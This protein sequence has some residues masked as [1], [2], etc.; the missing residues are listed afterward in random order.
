MSK[1]EVTIGLEIHAELNTKTKAFCGCANEYGAKPNTNVCHVCLAIPGTLP[2]INRAAVEKT[3]AAGLAID[4]K[5]ND[6]AVFERKHYFYPDLAKGYQ[7]SQLEKPICLGGGIKLGTG[8]FIRLN[9]IHLEEDAG[10]LLH[11]AVSQISLV[12]YNRGGVPLIEIVTEPD[13]A[14]ATEAVEFLEEVRQRLV[15]AG[16]AECR[17][18]QGGMRCDVNISL[19]PKGAKKLG[20]RC[21][22]KNLN[23]FKSVAR[24]I[25][26][27]AKRQSELLDKG[28]TI[29]VQ[30]RKW[31]EGAGKTTLMRDKGEAYDYR[32]FPD[33]DI[34]PIRITD[35][36]VAEIKVAM[37]KLAHELKT[38]FVTEFGLPEYDAHVLTKNKLLAHF[39]LDCVTLL[40]EPKAVS[41]WTMVD[42][43]KMM[44]DANTDVP[45][46][47]PAQLTEIIKMAMDKTITKTIGL[48]LLQKVSGDSRKSPK[49]IAKDMGLLDGVSDAE[50][51]KI[52]E[53]VKKD[54]PALVD[55]FKNN[56]QKVLPFIIGQ[57][58]K[59]TRGRAKSE[60]V[61]KLAKEFFK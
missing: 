48:E 34:Y 17:M 2:L 14:N 19:K 41:N 23:S 38:Q 30:T 37:P 21:E 28:E 57:V 58:M 61:E 22:V 25:E 27:E 46:V 29:S 55:D 3:I 51:K 1:Y 36:D 53:A 18:E 6:I 33:P 7:I 52:F 5:I 31:D 40:K 20:N 24:A 42:I 59:N 60:I 49:K 45:P 44:N 26:Y 10:K 32:Y 43:G 11:N 12:D 8:K 9:R 56:P 54:K 13:I 35:R 16:V 47:T 15:Y 39:Y 50:I 4:C